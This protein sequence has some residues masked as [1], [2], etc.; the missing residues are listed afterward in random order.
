MTDSRYMTAKEAAAALDVGLATLYAYV[1]RGLVRSEAAAG[2]TRARR[3][4]R[5]DV[6][7]LLARKAMRRNPARVV[8]EALHFGAPVLE[9]AITLIADGRF[10]YRGY[11][12]LHLAQTKRFEE[13]A[14]LIWLG[15]FSGESL[16]E[17][18]ATPALPSGPAL[19]MPAAFQAVLAQAADSD[20]AA[21]DLAE[22]AVAQT[23][24]RILHLLT[25]VATG[26][27]P[28]DGIAASLQRAWAPALPEATGLINAALI[29]CADHELNVSSFTA[30]CVA[31]AAATPYDVAIAGLAALHGAKHGGF[32]ERVEALFQE[33]GK[34]A[35]APATIASRLRRGEQIPGFGHKL[36]PEGD[37]RA[38]LLLQMVATAAPDAPALRLAQAISNAATTA[39]DALPTV[40]LALL[41]LR[42][43]LNLPP[44]SALTLFA[45]GRV[46]GWLGH[47]IEQYEKDQIIRPRA[48]Y[49]G[50]I[51]FKI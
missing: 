9:S 14:A 3:Y 35:A 36:Y 16:F 21:Y 40:D 30:R 44:G 23:G 39:V 50:Q 27:N 13:V 38:R 19:S 22:T 6:E 37:P 34:P 5:E 32:T 47:A 12:A 41:T 2:K 31:S 46:V 25:R 1:S 48:R 49:A 17:D 20:L 42:Q 45:L 24:A 15:D 33:T 29:L 28:V 51:P 7:A 26:A 4:R 8:E 10:Y 11:D 18:A 43:A